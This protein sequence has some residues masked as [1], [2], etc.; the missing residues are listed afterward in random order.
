MI[1][2]QKGATNTVTVTL[3]ENSTLT[4][5]IYLFQFTN[6]Q[7]ATD[8]YFIATDTSTFKER[9]NQ[10]QVVEKSNP[11]TLNGEVLLGNE[12]FY[13][14]Y[15]YETTLANT[16]GLSNASQAVI[17]IL[18]EVENGLVWVVP[19]PME[20]LEYDPEQTAIAYQ[21]AEDDYLLTQ[22]GD[23]LLLETGYLI[24]LE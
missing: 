5:P 12:G 7:T 6:Q 3:T 14:Y 16:S 20:K 13:N 11:D 23:Y 4:N 17:Y 15:V 22:S 18:N 9:Y 19:E 10:F 2:F 1:R 21:P 8:Y 24:E